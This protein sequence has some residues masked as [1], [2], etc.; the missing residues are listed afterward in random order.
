MSVA[1]AQFI[2]DQ[3]RNGPL[4]LGGDLSQQRPLLENLMTANPLPAG[5]TTT[6]GS[7]LGTVPVVDVIPE[8]VAGPGAIL[9]FHG[10]AYA[11]GSAL[12]GTGITGELV[13]RTGRPGVSVEYRLAPEHPYPAALDDAVA[14]YQGLLAKGSDPAQ[15]VVAGESAGAG[16][17]LALLMALRDQGL[18]RPTAAVLFSPWADLTASGASIKDRAELDPALS[19]QALRTRGADYAGGADPRQPGL[20]PLFGDFAGLPPLLVQVG[21]HEILLDDALR[22][23]VA[24]ATAQ[25]AIT[26]EV[27]PRMPH[28]FQG[29]AAVLDEGDTALTSAARFIRT[30]LDKNEI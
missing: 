16:L 4:D 9:Y 28:V 14:A 24:A 2:E 12:A 26:L 29:F 13:S 7:V 22:I 17:A 27:T 25:V 30:H 15:I 10:G 3:L 20:S 18:P 23:A 19:E 1:Q 6:T 21:T 11:L 8:T 5:V